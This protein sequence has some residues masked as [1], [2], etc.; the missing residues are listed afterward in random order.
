MGCNNYKSEDWK[1]IVAV[2]LG[3]LVIL[4][5]GWE[6]SKSV[7]VESEYGEVQVM[8]EVSVE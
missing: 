3:C 2:V 6:N 5:S 4:A 1:I 8:E 7:D